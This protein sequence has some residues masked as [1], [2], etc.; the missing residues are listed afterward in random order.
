MGSRSGAVLDDP[1]KLEET[2][3]AIEAAGRRLAC[4]SR[5]W[6]GSVHQ[7]RRAVR[8]VL[9]L[10][11]YAAVLVIFIVGLVIINN[12]MVWRRSAG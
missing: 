2:M 9:A 12:A 6:H 10:I 8:R 4:H 7:H 1:D 11:L 5:S 3:P